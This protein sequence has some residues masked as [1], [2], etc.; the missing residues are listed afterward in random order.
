MKIDPCPCV[1]SLN[2]GSVHTLFE[3]RHFLELVEDRMG[4][5]AAEWLRTHVEQAENA[6]PKLYLRLPD[7][8][9]QML[10]SIKAALRESPGESPVRV[11]VQ[12]TGKVYSM[13]DALCVSPSSGLLSRLQALLGEK[14]V[15]V[16]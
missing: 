10:Q 3:F 8:N 12:K 7:E 14:N 15:A 9:I 6:A 11:V 16:K 13:G 2:D 1:I 5:D 4:Y